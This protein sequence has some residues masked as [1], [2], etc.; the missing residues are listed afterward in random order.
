MAVDYKAVA[1][2][3]MRDPGETKWRRWLIYGRFK[4]GKTR[5]AST[6]PDVLML[7]PEDGTKEIAA[8]PD[9]KVWP[10]GQ[11]QDLDAVV[12]YLRGDHPWKWLV[13]DDLTRLAN[14]SLR[15]VMK[16]G[17]ERDLDRVPGIVDRRDYGKSG[18]LIK[19]LLYN[20]HALPINIIYTAG[21]R[22]DTNGGWDEGEDEDSETVEARFVPDL[23]K[24][25]RAA[26]NQ[27]VD[28][29]GRI[30]IVKVTGKNSQGQEVT[31]RQRRLWI[32]PTD[33]YDTGFRSKHKLP[34]YVKSPSVDRLTQLIE[35]GRI[36]NNG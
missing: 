27:I 26:V 16:L 33:K 13:V 36:T 3:M 11:W 2:K 15:R 12:H 25:A 17:E 32:A 24:G 22:M 9:L 4:A 20:L 18:E 30:Y 1:A 7:D 23:P 5:M 6:A 29:I 34:D 8:R 21:D 14:M 19:G 35:N 10:I 31:V 28:G